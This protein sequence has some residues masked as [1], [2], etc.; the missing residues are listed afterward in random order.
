[1]GEKCQIGAND[2]D[3]QNIALLANPQLAA[4]ELFHHP[5]ARPNLA[6]LENSRAGMRTLSRLRST[7]TVS[8]SEMLSRY[9]LPAAARRGSI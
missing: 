9:T 3:D 1:M 6:M 8:E 7:F 5:P 2:L 4:L